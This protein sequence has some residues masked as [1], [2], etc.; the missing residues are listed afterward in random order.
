MFGVYEGTRRPLTTTIPPVLA[1]VAAAMIAGTT[2]AVLSPFERIQTLLQDQK[3]QKQFRN[4]THAF[5]R[6]GINPAFN[7]KIA[8]PVWISGAEFGLKEAYRGLVPILLRNGPSNVLYFLLRDEARLRVHKTQSSWIG[9]LAKDFIC[10]GV[11]GGFISTIFYP[12][13]LIKVRIN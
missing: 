10:G 2:E 1:K 9:S 11:I 5:Y 12:L 4:T 3:Y 13:N 6:L 8:I 7:K